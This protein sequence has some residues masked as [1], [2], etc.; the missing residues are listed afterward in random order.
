MLALFEDNLLFGIH[1]RQNNFVY[2][3]KIRK[4]GTKVEEN[5]RRGAGERQ[6]FYKLE[7]SC[8][9][10]GAQAAGAALLLFPSYQPINTGACA[11]NG[12]H[13]SAGRCQGPLPSISAST[14]APEAA[15]K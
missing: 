1:G 4:D 14:P 12:Q 13:S 5:P 2:Q 3:G 7:N 11:L 9:R 8:F 15:M 10:E 6:T